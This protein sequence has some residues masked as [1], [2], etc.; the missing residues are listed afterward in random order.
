LIFL[1]IF[2]I[3]IIVNK[4]GK[5]IMDV[6][7]IATMTEQ[8]KQEMLNDYGEGWTIEAIVFDQVAPNDYYQDIVV[9][10]VD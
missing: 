3:I 1:K 2:V 10:I 9:K 6:K 7:I 5:I 4:K 8:E